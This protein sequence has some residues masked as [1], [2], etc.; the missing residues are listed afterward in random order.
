MPVELSLLRTL[1]AIEWT[2]DEP[3]VRH[4]AE[5]LCVEESTASR[6]VD[7][8]VAGGCVTRTISPQDRRRCLLALTD[9]GT[10]LLAKAT[11]VRTTFLADATADWPPAEVAMLSTLLERFVDSVSRKGHAR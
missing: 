10:R 5:A 7:Q 11:E 8:A 4:V 2:G 9:E 3:G 1:R 6:F